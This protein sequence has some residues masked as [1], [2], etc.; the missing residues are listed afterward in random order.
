MASSTELSTTS[1][2]RWCKPVGPVDPMYMLGRSRTAS[3]P[4]RTVD[5]VSPVGGLGRDAL[6]CHMLK[7]HFRLHSQDPLDFSPA[8]TGIGPCTCPRASVSSGFSL[9]CPVHS[10]LRLGMRGA[11]SR[12]DVARRA[13]DHVCNSTSANPSGG[14]GREGLLNRL[15]GRRAPR[16]TAAGSGRKSR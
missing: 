8:R 10:N 6:G 7:S 2:T 12:T 11:S 15:V 4:S 16:R 13:T 3:K 1:H 14:A 5:G 9:A